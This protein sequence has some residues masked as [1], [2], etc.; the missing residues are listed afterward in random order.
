VAIS[1]FEL[2]VLDDPPKIVVSALHINVSYFGNIAIID[3]GA[4]KSIS[5]K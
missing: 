4:F 3:V 2:N 1:P 5:L